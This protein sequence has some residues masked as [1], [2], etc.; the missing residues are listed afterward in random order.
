M[1]KPNI[2]KPRKFGCRLDLQNSHEL[3]K[4]SVFVTMLLS[5]ASLHE[6]CQDIKPLTIPTT[7]YSTISDYILF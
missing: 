6:Q 1:K 7:L 4:V 5:N 2:R 3:L